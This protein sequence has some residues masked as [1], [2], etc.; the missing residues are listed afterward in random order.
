MSVRVEDRKESRTNFVYETY[1]LSLQIGKI[2]VNKPKKYRMNF[3][4]NLIKTAQKAWKHT[5]IA[6]SIYIS[7]D[8]PL[9]D[10]ELRRKY[11]LK[12]RG[13]VKHISS[14]LSQFLDLTLGECDSE[15][16]PMNVEKTLKTEAEISGKCSEIIKMING[17]L[18][19]DRLLVDK[20]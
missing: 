12:A 1:K 19:H 13:E 9:C 10:Y 16:K 20:S 14:A 6:N 5:Q 15:S 8:T 7:K 17:V 11:L 18:K 4:D 2:V 3:G